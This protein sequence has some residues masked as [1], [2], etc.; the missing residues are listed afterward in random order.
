MNWISRSSPLRTISK[1]G[2]THVTDEFYNTWIAVVGLVFAIFGAVYLLHAA[3]EAHK[4]LH[5]IGYALYAFGS[6]NL[7]AMS[8]L[9]HG[10]DGSPKT[11]E[12]FRQLDY[13]AIF[14]MIAGTQSPFFLILMRNPLGWTI[15]GIEWALTVLG[16]V[17]KMG[18]P[19]VPKKVTTSI[20]LIMGWLGIFVVPSLYMQ[21]GIVPTLLLLSGGLLYTIG[22]L[23]FQLERPNPWPGKFGF[24]EIWH[25]MVVTAA[26]LH[27]CVMVYLLRL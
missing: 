15:F 27:F 24:H 17:L 9:H 11:E 1:D 7:F 22:S 21:G 23:I 4:T 2:S 12:T 26:I 19:R 6:I 18:F 8:V 5:I 3:A 10:I 20:Y 25:S 14:L 16:I 13:C